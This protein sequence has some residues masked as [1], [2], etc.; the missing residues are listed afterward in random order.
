MDLLHKSTNHVAT[1]AATLLSGCLVVHMSQS[2]SV[3]AVMMASS[4]GGVTFQIPSPN[5]DLVSGWL[6]ALLFPTDLSRPPSPCARRIALPWAR[7]RCRDSLML[8]SGDW[9]THSFI[10]HG[11]MGSP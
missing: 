8:S 2:S 4:N 5:F 7:L 6:V 11:V 10:I 1:A 9:L 3:L